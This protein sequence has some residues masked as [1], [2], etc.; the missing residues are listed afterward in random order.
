MWWLTSTHH[1]ITWMPN[2]RV[3]NSDSVT[4]NRFQALAFRFTISTVSCVI[5]VKATFT[6]FSFQKKPSMFWKKGTFVYLH[7][8]ITLVLRYVVNTSWNWRLNINWFV[9]L[10]LIRL[11]PSHSCQNLPIKFLRI[12]F[13]RIF[14]TYSPQYQTS[15]AM[16]K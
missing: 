11:K 10:N 12:Y 2:I 6:T 4:T 7:P 15:L 8:R 9:E 16:L 14:R 13:W 1:G 3:T 5:V